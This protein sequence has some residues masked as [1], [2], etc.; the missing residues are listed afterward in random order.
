M[1]MEEHKEEHNEEP[2]EEP[3]EK[4]NYVDHASL[5]FFTNPAYLSILQQRKKLA[6]KRDNGSEIKFYRKR[7]IALFK[8]LL[9]SETLVMNREIKEIHN[10]FVNSAIRHF[11]IIDTQDIVQRQHQEEGSADAHADAHADA[12]DADDADADDPE[13]AEFSSMDAANDSLMRKTIAVANLDNYVIMK[14]EHSTNDVRIIPFKLEIDLKT[15]D[16]KTKG[17]PP[18]K[19]KS[20]IKKEDLSN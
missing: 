5:T 12:D 3:K 6:E 10:L 1:Q 15:V 4:M 14:Q 11:E 18:R 8:D 7:I 20:K 17:V 19:L 13:L 2:K 16:L 9:K